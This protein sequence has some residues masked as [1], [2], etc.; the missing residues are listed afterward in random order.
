[1]IP[2]EWLRYVSLSSR[3]E[4]LFGPI[5]PD[6]LSAPPSCNSFSQ[7]VIGFIEQ[8]EDGQLRVIDVS[9]V[10][11]P[12]NKSIL[13]T[14]IFDEEALE[15]FN[16]FG[17]KPSPGEP[18]V[19][20]SQLFR[21]LRRDYKSL[22]RHLMRSFGLR[23][24]YEC[25]S[26]LVPDL[27][28][29]TST[30]ELLAGVGAGSWT[31]STS[32]RVTFYLNRPN[33][34][35]AFRLTA[36]EGEIATIEDRYNRIVKPKLSVRRLYDLLSNAREAAPEPVRWWWWWQPRENSMKTLVRQLAVYYSYVSEA[37]GSTTLDIW[38]EEFTSSTLKVDEGY[39]RIDL[40]HWL[41]DGTMKYKD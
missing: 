17:T 7:T 36:F 3:V 6:S 19:P 14:A 22:K 2:R 10:E 28:A 4:Y 34:D 30:S 16:D 25:R 9:H 24:F 20:R 35:G 41:T 27:G 12:G 32:L 1:M 31:N 8:P 11:Y 23:S 39:D 33:I 15:A 5:S 40:F 29:Q 21:E 13:F 18:R 38:P 26:I 37:R